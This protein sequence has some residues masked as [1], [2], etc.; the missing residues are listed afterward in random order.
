MELI[1]GTG[2]APREGHVGSVV[3]VRGGALDS[4][5]CPAGVDAEAWE[6]EQEERLCTL[7]DELWSVPS[8]PVD[9]EELA[10]WALV[11]DLDMYGVEGSLG[12]DAGGD[13][14]A[15]GE[16]DDGGGRSAPGLPAEELAGGL[17][18]AARG[19]TRAALTEDE[20]VRV[21]DAGIVSSTEALGLLRTEADARM[22]LL[23]L[24]VSDRGL[25]NEQGLSL[26]DWLRARCPWLPPQDATNV[27]Q[28][29]TCASLPSGGPL[30]AVVLAGKAPLHRAALAARTMNRLVRCLDVDQHEAYT[31]IV[32][33]AA[34][35]PK[36][37]DLELARVCAELIRAL[38]DEA[39]EREKTAEEL[40]KVSRRAIGEGLTRF[41]IDA[42]DAAAATLEGIITSKLAAPT[43]CIDEGGAEVADP[44]TAGQRQFD[45]L[46]TVVN[47]GL[48]NP[49]AAPSTARAAVLLVIPFDPDKGAPSGVA[50]TPTGLLVGERNAGK[51]SCAADITPVWVGPGNEPLALGHTARFA[52]PGQFKALVV[53]DQHCTFPGCSRPPQWCDTH[54]LVWWSRGGRTD[55]DQMALLCEQH[56][57]QVHLHEISGEVVGGHVV[58]HV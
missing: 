57:T 4:D 40:R 13:V 36:L 35:N 46:M 5:G 25:H 6:A 22:I 43:P 33:D 27:H 21:I 20:A 45:A 17:A 56:H 48:S 14:D 32:A 29:V 15:G 19:L 7:A 10:Y 54:H 3:E 12:P 34:A 49:G 47:R 23:A 52:S 37:S 28:I 9:A 30:K 16:A 24:Q 18:D 41:T 50:H 53:R 39:P 55:V 1:E 31:Q 58:W 26:V 44:R 51:L 42:P 38:L 2:Q 8:H 11:A